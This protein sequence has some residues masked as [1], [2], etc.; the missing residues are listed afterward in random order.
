MFELEKA[1]KARTGKM[2]TFSIFYESGV[3]CRS[4]RLRTR[5]RRTQWPENATR[6][7]KGEGATDGKEGKQTARQK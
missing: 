2:E 3:S 5:T 7:G 1:K 4:F 6:Q